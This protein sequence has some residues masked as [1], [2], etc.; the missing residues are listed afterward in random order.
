M[1]WPESLRSAT[2]DQLWHAL[3]YIKPGGQQ[4]TKSSRSRSGEVAESWEQNA[5]LMKEKAFPKPLKGVERKAREDRGE[6]WTLLTG[7]DIQEAVFDQLTKTAPVLDRFGLMVIRLLW[8]WDS[9]R[10]AEIVKRSLRLGIYPGVGKGA[11]GVAIPN[12]NKPD[13]GAAMAYRMIMLLNCLGKVVEHVA[14]NA[15]ASQCDQRRLLHDGQFGCRYRKYAIHTVGRLIK[16]VE[17]VWGRGIPQLR[18]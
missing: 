17:A 2:H 1:I 16:R 4:K 7:E 15:I 9:K 6:I 11:T 12:L 14:A 18:F 10:I 13:Y 5:E 8:N 3:R